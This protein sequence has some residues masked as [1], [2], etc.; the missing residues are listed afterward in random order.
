MADSAGTRRIIFPAIRRATW[1]SVT[2]PAP[3]QLAPTQVL[4]RLACTLVSAGTETAIYSGAHIGFTDP[5]A[6][7]PRMPF[8]PGY[9]A[10]GTVEAVG[11]D[12]TQLQP[13]DRVFGALPH[14]D[15]AVAD[16]SRGALL[17]LPGG[18]TFEQ[19][20]LARLAGIAMQGVRLAGLRFG[21]RAAVFGQGLIGQFARQLVTL[22]GA[23]TVVAVDPIVPRLDVARRHGATHTVDPSEEDVQA[24]IR[25]ATGGQ[26]VDVSIEATG[27]P[28]VIVDALKAA[29][30]MG[31]VVLL[32]S[33]RGKVEIDPYN[34]VHRKGVSIIGAHANTAA[35]APNQYN[36]F[37][38]G[39]QL[40]VAV[41]LM[42][43]GR[44]RTDGLVS[45]HLQ[46]ADALGIWDELLARPRD[47]LGVIIR[48]S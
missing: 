12:V 40:Q 46:A 13:G 1:E 48:W 43:Q 22:D 3:D 30:I 16:M 32:G 28:A 42:R 36:R 24:A 37:T 33:P 4:V 47:Y 19:G 38:T 21:E 8:S 15:H 11:R 45:H 39:E 34:D 41:E 7:Y 29:G 9:A 10:A 35:S 20:C 26:G 27:N 5:Q 14:A 18:V 31:R 25:A 17:P 6:T 2:L 23:T 44:L